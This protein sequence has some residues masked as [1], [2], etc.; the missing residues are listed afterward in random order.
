[1][2]SKV[3]HSISRPYSTTLT[4]I[5]GLSN[6]FLTTYATSTPH[7]RMWKLEVFPPPGWL[8]IF[9]SKWTE[10]TNYSKKQSVY[11]KA[12]N[13]VTSELRKAKTAYFSKMFGEVQSTSAY[14]NLMKRA[15]DPKAR[16]AIGPVKRDDGTLALARSRKSLHHELLLH[17]CRAKS[18]E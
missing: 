6:T 8:A 12:R 16:K 3:R 9:D 17:N 4:I 11:E 10:G 7:G 1:M 13:N 18:W 5:C 15:S 14:W 2:T